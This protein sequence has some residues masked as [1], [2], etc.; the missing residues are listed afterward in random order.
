MRMITVYPYSVTLSILL[1]YLLT[2]LRISLFVGMIDSEE[3]LALTIMK[4]Y[5]MFV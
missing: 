2:R 1:I 3:F 5:V 4:E